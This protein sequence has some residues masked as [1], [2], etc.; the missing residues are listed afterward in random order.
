[1]TG[2]ASRKLNRVASKRWRSRVRPAEIVIPDRDAGHERDRLRDPH[3]ERVAQAKL[4]D[5]PALMRHPLRHDEDDGSD[6]EPE[7]DDDR[8]SQLA[9]DP[10]LEEHARER[11]GKRPDHD[12]GDQPPPA[13][14]EVREQTEPGGEEVDE[15]RERRSQ[16]Q[17][18][19]E[20]ETVA[21]RIEM[22][23]V[24]HQDEVSGRAHRQELGQ[25][26]DDPQEHRGDDVVGDREVHRIAPRA[27]VRASRPSRSCSRTISR[28]FAQARRCPTSRKRIAVPP[29]NS[30]RPPFAAV[31][32]A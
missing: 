29:A 18:D 14:D 6:H 2:V 7:N 8:P 26:L 5:P 15:H 10:R 24:G 11:G 13:A 17:R 25:P 31:S 22:E 3:E 28:F 30:P 27:A 32:A 16:M 21:L 1:M 9:L 12:E 19:V 23:H 4:A 20:R